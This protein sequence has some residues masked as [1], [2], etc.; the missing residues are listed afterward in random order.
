MVGAGQR[1]GVALA[2]L[3]LVGT[4]CGRDVEA[5]SDDCIAVPSGDITLA[6]ELDLPPGEG[7]HSVMVMVH[8]SGEV[9]RHGF[10]GVVAHYLSIGVG[11]LRYDKR[12][13]DQS[14]GKYRDVNARNST[15]VFDLLVSD[16]I[17]L[18]DFLKTQPGIDANRIGLIG[19][20]QAGWVMPL[21][22]SRSEDIA[23]FISLSGAASTV[24]SPISTTSSP[25]EI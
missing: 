4:A 8:G 24:G 17:A 9:T 18:V 12:G 13:V 3:A 21:A 11:T 7:P 19:V 2:V 1:F 20:S 16:V 5:C 10:A 15:E 6:A 14:T 25:E 22:A 23:F